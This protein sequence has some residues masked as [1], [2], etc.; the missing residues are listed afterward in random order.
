MRSLLRLLFA[1]SAIVVVLCAVLLV[2]LRFVDLS[3]QAHRLTVP[4]SELSGRRVEIGG[5]LHLEPGLS[6]RLVAE[7]VSFGNAAWARRASMATAARVAA[8]LQLIP[9]LRGDFEIDGI[10]IDGLDLEIERDGS[11]QGNWKF[12]RAGSDGGRTRQAESTGP[13]TH[14]GWVEVRNARVSY[15]DASMTE[16]LV[17]QVAHFRAES[18]SAGTAVQI[19]AE[20][21]A[22]GLR[23]ELAGAAP[24]PATWESSGFDLSGKVALSV[25]DPQAAAA[26]LGLVPA[27]LAGA[28]L[29]A[30]IAVTGETLALRDIVARLAANDIG[31]ELSLAWNGDRPRLTGSVRAGEFSFERIVPEEDAAPVE[32][33]AAASSSDLPWEAL[34]RVDVAVS[35]A[36]G[37]LHLGRGGAVKNV[38]VD[39]KVTAGILEIEGRV[40]GAEAGHIDAKLRAEGAAQRVRV[41]VRAEDVAI[42]RLVSGDTIRGAR[43]NADLRLAGR[44][45]SAPAI[46]RSLGGEALLEVNG[47][48]FESAALDLFASDLFRQVV[49]LL[50]PKAHSG[51]TRL[52]CAVVKARVRAGMVEFDRGIALETEDVKVLGAG[53]LDLV[54]GEI[55]IALRTDPKGGAGVSVATVVDSL[56]RIRGTYA[57]PKIQI[58]P[59]GTVRAALRVGGAVLGGGVAL[60]DDVLKLQLSNDV[61]PCLIARGVVAPS[62]PLDG[63][64]ESAGKI[65]KA[66]GKGAGAAGRRLKKLLGR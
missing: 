28:L 9:L 24:P 65:G 35:M 21:T 55:D 4:L 30:N 64:A 27:A 45:A 29:S 5:G 47:G 13:R 60:I 33:R 58:D 57:E 11:G 50:R 38:D 41:D 66:V 48:T 31:G 49:D 40:G 7:Q 8:S 17:A 12:P 44:G 32:R 16:P 63:V 39:A 3:A 19:V 53:T 15:C 59:T 62:T 20:A 6:I 26:A 56:V 51:R 34:R 23:A 18:P 42:E 1:A 52:E 2:A 46:A 37:M 22:A 54:S 25:A 36:A 14:I 10:A 61:S 43:L